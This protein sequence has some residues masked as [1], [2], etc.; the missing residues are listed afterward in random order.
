MVGGDPDMNIIIAQGPVLTIQNLTWGRPS[1]LIF[2]IISP[3]AIYFCGYAIV[4]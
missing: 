1:L 4:G 2:A 3:V